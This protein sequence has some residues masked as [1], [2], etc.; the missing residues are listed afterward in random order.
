MRAIHE[1]GKLRDKLRSSQRTF[2]EKPFNMVFPKEIV[3]NI[4]IAE[5]LSSIDNTVRESL[6]GKA[7]I[8]L[9]KY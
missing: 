2:C 7:A 3:A 8:A 6:Y 1:T 5:L 9:V 4:A